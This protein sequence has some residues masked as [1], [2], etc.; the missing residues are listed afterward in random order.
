METTTGTTRL[1]YM[2]L[3]ELLGMEHPSNPKDHDLGELHQSVNRF[4]FVTPLVM[5]ERAGLLAEGHGR[6][7]VLQQKKDAGEHPPARIMVDPEAGDWLVPVVRGISFTSDAEA[8][9]FLVASNRLT[10]LGGWQEDRL[11]EVLQEVLEE[12]GTLS[13]VGADQDYLDDLLQRLDG[14]ADTEGEKDGAE[15]EPGNPVIQYNIIFDSESQQDAWFK[16]I[17]MLNSKYPD[18]ETI[19]ERLEV[20]CGLALGISGEL[21]EDG[22][23]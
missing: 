18:C 5:D 3:T 16:F 4:G 1:E 8:K 15:K 10:E 17:R 19:G 23:D 22:E 12:T 13:G 21:P 9:A 2:R 7:Q 6:L 14:G 11:A 20:Y